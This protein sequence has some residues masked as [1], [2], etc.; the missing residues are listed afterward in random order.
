MSSIRILQYLPSLR[1]EAGGPI[2]AVLDLATALAGRG[3]TVTIASSDPGT[4]ARAVPVVALGPG[5]VGRGALGAAAKRQAR[6]LVE[7]ADIVH[8]HGAWDYSNAQL[9]RMARAAGKP[10]LVS[11]RGMLDD[12]CMRQNVVRKRVYHALVGR[13]MLEHAAAVHCTAE[14]ELAQ[15]KKWFPKGRGV[16]LPNFL[17]LNPFRNAP[18]PGLAREK[19]PVL[20]VARPRVLFLSRLHYKKGADVFLEAA[21]V[22]TKAGLD[23]TWVLAGSGEPGYEQKMKSLAAAWG[24]TDRVVFTGHVGGG[25]KVSLYQACEVFALP[26][27]QENFGFVF[28]ESLACGIPVITTKGVDIWPELEASGGSLIVERTARAFAEAVVGLVQDEPRRAAMGRAGAEWVFDRFDEG[29]LIRDF[30]G[31]YRSVLSCKVL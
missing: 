31:M 24:L 28:P 17:D 10:Y 8:V 23:A 14:G 22:A 3:H 29:R 1:E 7:N 11:P 2:R 16:V 25:M 4:A 21:A 9:G 15:S 13:R 12:W 19:F 6:R 5:Y 26:T 18:G 27:S 30:E 20:A